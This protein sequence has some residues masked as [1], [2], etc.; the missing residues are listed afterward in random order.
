LHDYV[1]VIKQSTLQA[2][3]RKSELG[4][5]AGIFITHTHTHRAS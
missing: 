2:G 1:P 4:Y 5:E 3:D